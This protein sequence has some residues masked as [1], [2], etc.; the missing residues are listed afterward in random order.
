MAVYAMY[1]MC[2]VGWGRVTGRF[3]RGRFDRSIGLDSDSLG[4]VFLLQGSRVG[5]WVGFRR[6]RMVV[7]SGLRIVTGR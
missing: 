2:R 7:F 6:A 1:V 5:Q 4:V 3:D